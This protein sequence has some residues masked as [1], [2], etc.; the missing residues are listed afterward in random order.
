MRGRQ[1]LALVHTSDNASRDLYPVTSI[2]R[3]IHTV[4]RLFASLAVIG[5][6]TLPAALDAQG[7]PDT[8]FT[9]Q[10]GD[11]L[12][13]TFWREPK[14]GGEFPV[15]ERGQATL[16]ILGTRTVTGRPWP[17]L[18][19]SLMAQYARELANPGDVQILP[20]RRVF[21]L[22]SVTKPGAYLADPTASIAAAVA[23]AGGATIDGSLNRVRVVRNGETVLRRAAVDSPLATAN[24]QSGDQVFV[25]RRGWL[26]RNS[27][28]ALS[29]FVGLAGVIV[30]LIVFR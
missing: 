12:T 15:D 14:L 20:M 29:T 11:V 8:N 19:D 5:L 16:P 24:V 3:Y 1:K 17:Q 28:V 9:L 13:V 27:A 26:D 7:Q 21:V 6:V 10:P 18:R 4:H 30:T 23:L 2:T 25:D 22:G